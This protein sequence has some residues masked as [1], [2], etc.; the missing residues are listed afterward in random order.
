[1]DP[2]DAAAQGEGLGAVPIF[3][4]RSVLMKVPPLLMFFV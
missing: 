1:V 2:G 4:G 3:S